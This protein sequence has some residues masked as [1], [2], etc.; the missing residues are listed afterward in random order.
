MAIRHIPEPPAL[1]AKVR[2]PPHPPPRRLTPHRILD[3]ISPESDAAAGALDEDELA[4][5]L[6]EPAPIVISA[7]AH[8]GAAA[9]HA[10]AGLNFER[11]VRNLA[12]LFEIEHQLL[13]QLADPEDNVD[14]EPTHLP[15]AHAG[16][17]TFFPGGAHAHGELPRIVIPSGSHSLPTSPVASG[18]EPVVRTTNWKKAFNALGKI[19]SP[20]SPNSG[21]LQGWWEDPDDPVHVIHRCA[22]YIAELWR[23]QKVHQKLAEKRIRLE[24]SSGL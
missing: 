1:S 11:H 6:E 8:G 7:N 5:T 24:E 22:P 18:S 9:A 10:G 14:K 16:A 13:L 21:E 2:A 15:G 4:S 12:P 20:K 23:D 19:Q 17:S 3:A